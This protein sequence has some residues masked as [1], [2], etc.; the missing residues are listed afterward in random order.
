MTEPNRLQSAGSF[1][2][3]RRAVG[4]YQETKVIVY[5]Y[6]FHDSDDHEVMVFEFEENGVDPR[7]DILESW[8]LSSN[9]EANDQFESLLTEHDIQEVPTAP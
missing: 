3:Q 9:E 1:T 5:Q 8:T 7:G 2:D 6:W 4:E